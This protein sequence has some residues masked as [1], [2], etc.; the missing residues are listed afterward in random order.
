MSTPNTPA[1]TALADRM[2]KL[3][4]QISQHEAAINRSARAM[5]TVGLIALVALSVYFYFGY[6]MIADLL[7]PNKLVPYGAQMLSDRLPDAR[8]ALVKQIS[9]SAPAWAKETSVQ[10]RKEIPAVRVKLETY[11]MSNTDEMLGKV[12]TL[13]EDHFRKAIHDNHDLLEN[14]FKEL[15]NSKDLTDETLNAL[16]TALEQ[17]LKSDMKDQAATV[18]ETLRYLSERVQRL[19]TGKGLDEQ[20]RYMRQIL[21]IAR[22]MRDTTAD[23]T[24]I[25][26]PALKSQEPAKDAT[27][28]E[29]PAATSA[30]DKATDAAKEDK[31]ESKSGDGAK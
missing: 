22:R 5:M 30:P 7:E 13:T 28:S 26:L 1:A 31:A 14:G 29:K 25:K 23:D 15:A 17:E 8:K 21:M 10:A 3:T 12:T 16:V 27:D 24:P 4:Q 20:E 18:L 19:S 6:T 2:N 9:D 11:V